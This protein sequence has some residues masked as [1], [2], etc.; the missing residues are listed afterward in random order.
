[1]Q[2]VSP[3]KDLQIVALWYESLT[4][5]VDLLW[6]LRLAS[7][8]TEN[9]VTVNVALD[10]VSEVALVANEACFLC[11]LQVVTMALVD[12]AVDRL[13]DPHYL[14]DEPEMRDKSY[15][16]TKERVFE[17]SECTYL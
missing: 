17:F 15:R 6:L 9:D 13:L 10:A 3:T 16:L 8:H 4:N 2:I 5:V 11:M 14:V 12:L 7:A 1:M